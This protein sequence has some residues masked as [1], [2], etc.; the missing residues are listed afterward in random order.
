MIEIVIGN[1]HGLISKG[2]SS[3]GNSYVLEIMR[4]GKMTEITLIPTIPRVAKKTA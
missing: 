4:A 2:S 3:I 1:V